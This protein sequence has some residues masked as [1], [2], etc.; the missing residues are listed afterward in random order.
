MGCDPCEE[1]ARAYQSL[2]DENPEA[3]FRY[4]NA[5][6]HMEMAMDLDIRFTPTFVV[7][8]NSQARY[9]IV[10]PDIV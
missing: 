5:L 4:V 1:F 10:G 8:V 3:E 6:D 2:K 9:S 7:M